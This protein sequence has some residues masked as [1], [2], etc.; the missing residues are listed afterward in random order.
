MELYILD[1]NDL[2]TLSILECSSYEINLDNQFTDKSTFRVNKEIGQIKDNFLVVNGLYQQFLFKIDEVEATD[3]EE[4]FV[5]LVCS[6][7]SNI[8]NRKI[9]EQETELMNTRSIEYFLAHMIDI[10]FIN[11]DDSFLNKDYIEVTY[12]EH[13]QA[14]VQTN[15]ENGI[16]NFHTFMENCREYQN[17]YTDFKIED[18]KLKITISY[19]NDTPIAIDTTLEEVTHYNKV[20]E[21]DITAKVQVYIREN[22]EIRNYFLKTDRTITTDINDSNRASGA[23]EVIS[24]ETPDDALQEATNVFKG[25]TYKHLVEFSISKNSKLVDTSILYIGRPI[26]IKTPDGVYES[27]ISGISLDD[28]NYVNFKSGNIRINFIDKL[29]QEKDNYGNKLDVTGGIIK[30]NLTTQGNNNVQGNENVTGTI[31]SNNSINSETS[32]NNHKERLTNANIEPKSSNDY[33][34]FRHDVATGSMISN[35]P[36]M[37]DS[38]IMTYF[39]DNAGRYDSQMAIA[40]NDGA[41]KL[42]GVAFRGNTNGNWGNWKSLLDMIYPVGSIYLSWNST[43]PATLFGGTWERTGQGG[44]LY[45]CVNSSGTGNGT[46]T[47]TGA[48]STDNT[49]ASTG[50]TGGPS[51]NS[52]GSVTLT[53]NQSGL[54]DHT[55][56]ERYGGSPWVDSGGVASA[57]TGN[58]TTY[59]GTTSQKRNQTYGSGTANAT[60]AHSHTL[61]N[62][63]HSL[64]SHTHS[65][66]HTHNIPY[67][68]VFVWRRT[69]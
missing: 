26:I 61:N 54:R 16:Y 69:A 42:T 60:E 17:V 10:N 25:N 53:S 40:N 43:S 62:H 23:I 36:P 1:N 12:N 11:S 27:I 5:N 3:K 46:G 13:T 30:G 15:A 32:F 7:I 49:G 66:K 8:F 59:S 67:V 64:N 37:G 50:S 35:K 58:M 28:D 22:G 18:K 52:T 21:Q 44:F 41:N 45:S 9:I 19:K 29:K 55:H 38:H 57:Q 2:S 31:K 24:V 51:N 47:A 39:W 33:G 20:Y 56:I 68:A 4:K 48:S 63:T 14:K 34:G 65:M 6:D